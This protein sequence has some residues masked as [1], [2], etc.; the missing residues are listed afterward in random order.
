MSEISGIIFIGHLFDWLVKTRGTIL[1]IR[2][3]SEKIIVWQMCYR[4]QGVK[5][6]WERKRIFPGFQWFIVFEKIHNNFESSN[7]LSSTTWEKSI[8]LYS[9]FSKLSQTD[10]SVWPKIT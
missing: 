7:Q 4:K 2:I 9:G 3:F 8:I 5:K 6:V 1:N 10:V